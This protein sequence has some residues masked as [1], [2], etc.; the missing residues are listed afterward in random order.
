MQF[1]IGTALACS[2]SHITTKK[3]NLQTPEVNILDEHS[4]NEKQSNDI[5]R[6]LIF[7]WTKIK[8]TF[9]LNSTQQETSALK[10]ERTVEIGEDDHHVLG[11][12][13]WTAM[14]RTYFLIYNSL[15]VHAGLSNCQL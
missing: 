5:A 10:H 6:I 15:L 7:S 8:N 14:L 13:F 4:I 9:T 12:G 1:V 3:W 2:S 11:H